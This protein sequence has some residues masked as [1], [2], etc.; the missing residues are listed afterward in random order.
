M[1]LNKYYLMSALFCMALASCSDDVADGQSGN[2]D[3]T[4]QA[5]S[6]KDTYAT[7]N[8]DFGK[9]I[10]RSI[11]DNTNDQVNDITFLIFKYNPNEPGSGVLE[12]FKTVTDVTAATKT[13]VYAISSG[14]KKVFALINAGATTA[15]AN[16]LLTHIQAKCPLTLNVTSL[17]DFE[18]VAIDI[19]NAQAHYILGTSTSMIMSG[20]T[21]ANLVSGVSATSAAA[22]TATDEEKALGISDDDVKKNQI[23]VNVNR[24][25]AKVTMGE[26]YSADESLVWDISLYG[27]FV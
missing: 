2:P 9:T 3:N 8:L 24:L 25:A 15:T 26:N 14:Q 1:K 27:F 7:F 4:E 22:G 10:S 12:E 17:A 23:T 18:K 6:V 11:N 16:S 13:Q 5:E 20:V 21:E 19:N